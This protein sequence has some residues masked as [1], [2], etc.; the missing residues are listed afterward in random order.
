M[1]EAAERIG[2][3]AEPA[4]LEP[5]EKN[6][7]AVSSKKTCNLR[8]SPLLIISACSGTEINNNWKLQKEY[9]VS[10][11]CF[12]S[13]L[14]AVFT[15]SSC[16]KGGRGLAGNK[17]SS[18]CVCVCFFCFLCLAVCFLCDNWEAFPFYF[19][20]I[21]T[22]K[23]TTADFSSYPCQNITKMRSTSISKLELTCKHEIIGYLSLTD[24]R[25]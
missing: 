8:T 10:A 14:S 19:A 9:S 4:K 12:S 16:S 24:N 1:C 23:V 13:H 5:N 6:I 15:S 7:T 20:Q 25:S 17:I 22:F 21:K 3:W 11:F 2:C 18:L